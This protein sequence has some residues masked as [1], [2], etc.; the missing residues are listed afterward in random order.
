MGV[1]RGHQGNWR[2]AKDAFV[3]AIAVASTPERETSLAE[4]Q[5]IRRLL[6]KLATRPSDAAAHLQLGILLMAWDQGDSALAHFQRAIALA[7]H[8]LEAHFCRGLELHYRKVS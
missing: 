8:M 7:P 2:W 1:T 5:A 3:R 6:G 4:V